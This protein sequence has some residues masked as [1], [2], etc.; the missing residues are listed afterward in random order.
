MRKFLLAVCFLSA[1]ALWSQTTTVSFTVVD[2]DTT[3][4]ANGNWKLEFVPNFNYPNT[5]SY[6]QN[7]TPLS[8]STLY[9]NG[10]LNGS[11]VGSFT[12][13]DSTTI[14]PVGSQWKLT[15][16]PNSSAPCGIYTFATA[17]P[18]M[19]ISSALTAIIPAP[20]FQA[21]YPSY[22]YADLEAIPTSVPGSTYYNVTSQCQRYYNTL[23]LTWSCASGGG[24]SPA[25]STIS[26]GTNTTAAMLVGTGGSL[27]PIGSGAIIATGITG[28]PAI[29]VSSCIGCV[30]AQYQVR[31]IAGGYGDGVNAIPAGTYTQVTARTKFGSTL[32]ITGVEGYSDN[33]GTST[34]NVS[35]NLSHLLITSPITLTNAW[36][37]GTQSAT[38]TL[39]TNSY[40]IWIFV[41][42]GTSKQITCNLWGTI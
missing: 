19:N 30:P 38:T 36:A 27:A 34:C 41:A 25:F 24:G 17:G 21:S 28:N 18:T 40:L 20:R 10:V 14:T 8:N 39:A 23:A 1:T 16:C 37:A 22:G 15:M 4:W 31:S 6:N 3:V 13:Y 5:A 9:Q 2:S 42:D 29:G 7:G 12:T 26:S 11:G 33:N 32:T 35:D